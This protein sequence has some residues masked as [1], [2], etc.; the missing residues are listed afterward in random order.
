M[1]KTKKIN[2]VAR[3][4]FNAL[5]ALIVLLVVLAGVGIYFRYTII[6]FI[7]DNQQNKDYIVAFSV[8]DIRYTTPDHINIGDKVYLASSGS[9]MGELI[10]ESDNRGALNVTPAS[11]Y[12]HDDD[13]N[14][15]EVF[16]SQRNK[17]QRKGQNDMQRAFQR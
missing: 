10:S 6:D 13:G 12:F 1:D 11:K 15:I 5:D 17:S 14:V 8:E 9:Y 16:L 4:R 2:D 3:P 7:T